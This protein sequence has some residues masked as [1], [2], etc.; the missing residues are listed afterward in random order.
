MAVG[1]TVTMPGATAQMFD[2]VNALIDPDSHPP[3]GL[4]FHASG[5][6]EGGWRAVDVW[7][8]RGAFDRFS[9]ERIGPAIAQL[10]VTGLRTSRSSRFTSISRADDANR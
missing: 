10:G 2:R 1:I 4:P 7:E 9:Q 8:S 5:P 6:V 3:E